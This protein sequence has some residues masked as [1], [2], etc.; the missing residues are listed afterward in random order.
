MSNKT[1]ITPSNDSKTNINYLGKD[2]VSILTN[3]TNLSKTYFPDTNK[4]FSPNSPATMF[5]NQVAYIGD[6]LNFYI[7]YQFKESF[8]RLASERKNIILH[9]DYFGY[10]PKLSTAATV[11]LEVFQLIPSIEISGSF[12]PD[13]KYALFIKDGLEVSNNDSS[14]IFKTIE[15]VDFATSGSQ[16]SETNREIEVY[17]RTTYGKPLFY[18]LKKT[19]RAISAQTIKRQ[20]NVP[21]A[22]PFYQIELPDDNVLQVISVKDS[23]NNIWYEVPYLSQ[24]TVL[25]EE[26]NIEK[27]N[28]LYSKWR[29]SVPYLLKYKK[30]PR[31]FITRVTQ[32]NKMILEFGSG[33]ENQVFDEIIYPSIK[34]KVDY[35]TGIKDFSVDPSVFVNSATYGEMPSNTTLTVEYLVG[36]GVESNVNSNELTSISFIEFYNDDAF[37]STQE[38]QLLNSVKT[39]VTVNNP[40]SA[41]GGKDIETDEEIRQKSISNFSTQNRVVTRDDFVSR[42]YSLPPKYGTISKVFVSQ[43]GQL[44]LETQKNFISKNLFLI[45]NSGVQINNPFAINLYVLSSDFNKK[46]T[47]IN[48]ALSE[49]LI[50]YLSAYRML[51]DGINILDAFIINIGINFEVSIYPS[52]NKKEVILNCIEV[53]KA[54]FDIDKW[55][56]SQPIILSDLIL[57]LSNVEGVQT[58]LNVEILNKNKNDGNYS[59]YE[60]DIKSATLNGIIYPS[61]DPSIFELKFPNKDIVG[62]Y[63][64]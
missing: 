16:I 50:T 19:A 52:Y 37:L 7:D 36:G 31:R 21:S 63:V 4:D 39:S 29:D 27:N 5:M 38:Q 51:T 60:Y 3:L 26:A 34:N 32:N 62:R 28:P 20:Y 13:W 40:E 57:L 2:Y 53:L 44:D 58:V 59:E 64:I 49:N 45:S 23:D 15:P 35:S 11:D 48:K 41:V 9:S 22:T 10:K 46:L 54:Y 30:T 17:S 1:N 8:Q 47:K 24:E 33:T 61:L 43:D 55:Q 42:V 18:L 6:V 56:I 14:V 25:I 12:Y